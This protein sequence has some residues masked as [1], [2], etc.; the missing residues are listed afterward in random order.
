MI[1]LYLYLHTHTHTHTR[2]RTHTHTHTHK[3]TYTFTYIHIYIQPVSAIEA[4]E[5]SGIFTMTT[6][7]TSGVARMWALSFCIM[8]GQ[9]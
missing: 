8:T 6:G 7:A 2:A 3:H 1:F 9:S 5:S 4:Y